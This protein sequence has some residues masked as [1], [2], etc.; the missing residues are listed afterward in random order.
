MHNSIIYKKKAISKFINVE[1]EELGAVGRVA[2]ESGTS[3]DER[4][5]V[6]KAPHVDHHSACYYN[7][8]KSI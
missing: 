4:F 7:N 1:P 3:A 5:S 6:R 2:L 8:N